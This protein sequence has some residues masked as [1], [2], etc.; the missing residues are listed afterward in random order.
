MHEDPRAL[1]AALT[2]ENRQLNRSSPLSSCHETAI[3]KDAFESQQPLDEW[4]VLMRDL[5]DESSTFDPFF[6]AQNSE[7]M[8]TL[9]NDSFYM[10]SIGFQLS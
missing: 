6:G 2:G 10:S 8:E 4:A 3:Q 5:F 1:D 7:D 9:L